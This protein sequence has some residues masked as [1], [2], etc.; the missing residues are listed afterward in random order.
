MSFAWTGGSVLSVKVVF[1]FPGQGSQEVGMGKEIA[2]KFQIARDVFQKANDVLGWDI[3]KLCFEGPA[4]DLQKTRNTQPAIL[5]V[6]L[7]IQ[8]VLEDWGIVPSGALGHSLGEYAALHAAGVLDFSSTLK[9][10]A[11]RALFME[12]AANEKPGGMT[13]ILGAPEGIPYEVCQS[14]A[15]RGVIGVANYNSPTQVVISGEKELVNEAGALIKEKGARRIIP[16]AVS[17]AFHTSLMAGAEEKLRGELVGIPFSDPKFP[18]I[19]NVTAAPYRNGT[20]VRELLPRQI[21]SP[22]RFTESLMKALELG[23]QTYIEVGPGAVLTGLAKK[24][25]PPHARIHSVRCVASLRDLLVNLSPKGSAKAEQEV[26][27]EA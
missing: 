2:E 4:E 7:A 1:L 25:L 16:L 15:S 22:V 11:K 6:S 23:F 13:A 18:V 24:T 12:E 20:E 5:T 3:T 26:T 27:H 17:G 21:T 9:F 8:V 10:I 19:S 14:L